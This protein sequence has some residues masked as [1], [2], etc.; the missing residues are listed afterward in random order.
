M[1]CFF[2]LDRL[3]AF[4]RFFLP[5]ALPMIQHMTQEMIREM[6]ITIFIIVVL[7]GLWIWSLVH[8]F[9]QQELISK[10]QDRGYTAHCPP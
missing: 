4:A 6:G 3:E 5:F 10:D 7:K 8:C 2:L 1:A 9:P